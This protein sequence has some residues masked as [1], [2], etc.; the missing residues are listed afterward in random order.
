MKKL[1]FVALFGLAGVASATDLGVVYNR[2]YAGADR[3]GMGLTLGKS[4]GAYGVTAGFERF[5][6]GA[7]DQNR[8]SLVGSYDVT[9]VG[10]AT[11]AVKAGA[12]Y[13]DNQVG[14]N[15]YAALVGV[16]VSV[17][18]AKNLAVTADFRHQAGQRRVEA[19]DG[20]TLG[21]G[22]KYSF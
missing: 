21:V 7:N 6:R 19:F 12:A 8:Y 13:L 16:G 17:P 9:K 2:D 3:N 20:N 15:G 1:L 4:V 14:A 5:T 11:V 18:V 22:L 10:V